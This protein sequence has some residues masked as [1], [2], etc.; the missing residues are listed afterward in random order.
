M[1]SEVASR[2]RRRRDSIA[3]EYPRRG[4]GAAA[5]PSPRTI[6]VAAAG[7]DPRVF[8]QATPATTMARLLLLAL[9]QA[10]HGALYAVTIAQE[11]VPVKMETQSVDESGQ[12][13]PTT[14][15]WDAGGIGQATG[16]FVD[17]HLYILTGQ[18]MTETTL[19]YFR[20]ADGL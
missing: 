16:A 2:P 14:D 20:R 7:V 8:P 11:Q 5:I 13:A 4:R 12:M 9:A 17:D 6:R 15:A 18:K 19:Q 10:A 1:L 3:T